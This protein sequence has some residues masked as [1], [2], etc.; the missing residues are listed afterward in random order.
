LQGRGEQVA[1]DFLVIDDKDRAVRRPFI[2]LFSMW[3][4]L[5]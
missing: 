4:P 2:R 5:K 3:L 1:D